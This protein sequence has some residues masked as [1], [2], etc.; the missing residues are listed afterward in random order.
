[1]VEDPSDA[2]A[3][4]CLEIA[5]AAAGGAP[6]AR[7][8]EIALESVDILDAPPPWDVTASL[9]AGSD[10]NPTLLPDEVTGS[11]P[12]LAGPVSAQTDAVALLGLTVARHPLF[13]HSG[14]TLGWSLSA[15]RA[16]HRDLPQLDLTSGGLVASL[17]WGGDTAGW[18]AGPLGAVRVPARPARLAAVIQA[19]G[20]EI[21]LGSSRY[22]RDVAGS[23]ALFL[24]EAPQWTTRIEVEG[25]DRTF[26]LD[27]D[28]PFRRS[29]TEL[30]AALS[31]VLFLGRA[32]RSVRLGARGGTRGGG[33]AFDGSFTEA[34]VEARTPLGGAWSLSLHGARREDRFAHEESNLTGDGPKRS[35]RTWRLA[36]SLAWRLRSNLAWTA[37]ALKTRRDSNVEFPAGEPLFDY[38]RTLLTT[39]LTWSLQ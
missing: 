17:A 35:D 26:H 27:G 11:P 12:L 30:S 6:P 29:G 9:A 28:D 22:L 34:F 8:P 33:R 21:W 31:Q 15:E 16:M 23:A 3:A 37:S 39:G 1:M 13:N 19:G 32:D 2:T 36:A 7:L 18:L 10:S 38:R 25:H 14:W 20:A 4:R 24:R 5:K